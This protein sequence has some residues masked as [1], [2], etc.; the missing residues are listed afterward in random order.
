[1][2]QVKRY[3]AKSRELIIALIDR[4]HLRIFK[5]P[6]GDKLKHFIKNFG[7]LAS[8]EIIGSVIG[9][10]VKIL[11]GRFLGPVEYGKYALI[12]NLVQFF[13]LPMIFGFT[14]AA[15]RYLP[16]HKERRKEIIGL[17]NLLLTF[18]I[19]SS[20]VGF[21]LTRSLWI[22][23]FGITEDLF[24]WTLI[25][26]VVTV[27][28][29]VYDA[30][31][32]GLDRFRV[33][34]FITIINSVIALT[35]FL[36]FIFG[37]DDHSYRAYVFALIL[38]QG[39]A[40]IIF[41]VLHLLRKEIKIT[42]SKDLAKSIL[43]YSGLAMLTGLAS[44]LISNVD[45]FFLNHYMTLFWVGVYSAYINAGNVF[46]GR[47]F[48]LFLNVYFPSISGEKDKEKIAAMLKKIAIIV[49]IPVFIISALSIW[50]I[51]WL[52]GEEF[53]IR[54]DLI[55]LFS[56]NN[57]IYV[58]YQLYMWLIN[59]QGNK[60]VKATLRILLL[61]AGL[62]VFLLFTLVQTMGIHGAILSLIVVNSIFLVYF[63]YQTKRFLKNKLFH[64]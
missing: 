9:F 33:L 46:I 49:P 18:T 52:F 5:R 55:L 61:N 44:F 3:A 10:P 47:F 11:A 53:P 17:I 40:F 26:T 23:L 57:C 42:Y 34:F 35:T 41:F 59:S 13:F 45:R 24:W 56:V 64:E 22:R 16:Q 8:A 6:A 21:I 12:L 30:F 36:L 7:Y 54:L 1:M 60:G 25:I 29:R 31:Q 14:T 19:S 63:Y 38:A 50:G 37:L 58:L 20:V 28:Y 62:N 43:S 4:I 48:Q 39:T 32:R 51:I 15:L 27:L 2:Q